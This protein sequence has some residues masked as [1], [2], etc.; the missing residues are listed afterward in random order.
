MTDPTNPDYAGYQNLEQLA[1]GYRNSG[2][3]AQR[4]KARADMLEQQLAQVALQHTQ[5]QQP[6]PQPRNVRERLQEVGMPVDDMLEL[7]NTALG[8]ALKP[9]YGAAMARPRMLATYGDDFGKFESQIYAEINKDPALVQ[10]HNQLMMTDP[11]TA[12]EWAY[13]RYAEQQRR[14]QPSDPAPNGQ[15]EQ[16]R[17]EASIPNSRT[18]DQRQSPQEADQ[19]EARRRAWEIFK[20]TGNPEPF[21]RVRIRETLNPDAFK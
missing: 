8:D 18:G 1:Q 10:R 19:N 4:Q 15:V 17:S 7:V 21:A 12:A 6:Q 5:Q 11:E 2:Q 13:L 20:T 14:H 9:M 3:E 16:A